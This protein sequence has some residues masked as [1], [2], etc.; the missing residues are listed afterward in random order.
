MFGDLDE[1]S[2]RKLQE[3]IDRINGLDG[4]YLGIESDPKD[5]ETLKK[6]IKETKDEIQERNP[7]KALISSIKDMARRSMTGARKRR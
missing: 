4:A 1:I 3:L 2:T 5:L 7:F 6:K